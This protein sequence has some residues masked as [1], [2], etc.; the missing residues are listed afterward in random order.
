MSAMRAMNGNSAMA[1]AVRQVTPDVVMSHPITPISPVIESIAESVADGR[2]DAEFVHAESGTSAISG[3]IG[4]S[5]AGGRVFTATS[6]Q[7]LA[8]MHQMLMIAS[9]L[10]LPIVAAVANRALAAPEN[11][12]AD[13][14]DTMAQRDNGWIHIYSENPQ[15]AYDNLVQAFKIAEHSDVRTPVIV[16]MD[17]FV[18]SHSVENL[19]V[20]EAEDIGRFVGKF[21]SV[22]SLLDNEHP[23]TAGS[24]ARSDYYFEHK[25]SQLQGIENSRQVIKEIGR[26]FGDRFGRYYGHFESYKLEDADFAVVLM[27][28]AA[29]TAKEAVDQLRSRGEKAGLLKLRVFRPFPYHELS[30]TLSRLTAVAVLDRSVS[31]GG[32]GGPLFNEIRSALYDSQTKPKVFPY[33]YG[34]GGREISPPDIEEIFKEI[35]ENS[36]THEPEGNE[37]E[38]SGGIGRTGT[39]SV[40]YVNLRS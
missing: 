31:P 37:P 4:A 16:G 6:S 29:G 17:G 1:E 19:V 22:Y 11:V 21:E 40:K 10:R 23:V 14:S 13:H 20:E 33:I 24:H 32:F 18:T 34:L 25:V 5:A 30:D 38:E 12:Q 26:E 39:V 3:C 35:R 9:S 28:S 36:L 8:S 7:D 27:S 2:I 15:E